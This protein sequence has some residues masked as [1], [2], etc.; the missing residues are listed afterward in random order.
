MYL[1]CNQCGHLNEVK[2]PYLVFCTGCNKKLENNFSSWQAKHP[3]K[4][5][6]DFQQLMC[7]SDAD[8]QI[9][10]TEKKT[11]HK[12]MKYWIGFVISFAVF[13]AI[14]QFGGQSIVRF[15]NFDKTPENIMQKDWVYKSYG[16]LGLSLETPTVLKKGTLALP[17]EIQQ[18]IE[19]MDV[20]DN[21]SQKGFKVTANSIKYSDKIGQANL[22]GAAEGS[23]NEMKIQKGVT[24][25]N[26]EQFRVNLD[27]IPGIIQSGTY[28]HK[29]EAVEF[30]NAIFSKGTTTW[31]V[32]V[33]WKEDD[34][35][36][37]QAGKRIIDSIKINAK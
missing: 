27:I 14:G 28:K 9:K 1:K 24:D 18:L 35:F 32:L 12:S 31:Q 15:F 5:Y 33:L 29:G 17:E 6:E 16:D 19:H 2:S 30:T 34:I 13:Y 11:K 21:M 4:S 37:R 36:G 25:F 23:V 7:V 8:L 20:Y 22:E 10:N 3:E 26:Y